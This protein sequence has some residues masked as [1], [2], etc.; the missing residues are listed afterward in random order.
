VITA[1][2]TSSPRKFSAVSF[3]FCRMKAETWLGL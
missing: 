3:I 1:W 2:V